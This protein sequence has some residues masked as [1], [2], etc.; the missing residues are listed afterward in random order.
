MRRIA[1]IL[2]ALALTAA[3]AAAQRDG[4]ADLR[5]TVILISLDGFRWDYPSK[6]PTPNL[7]RLMARG[8]HA[9]NLIPSFPSKTFPNHYTIVT[10]LYPGHHGI[11]AN[12]IFDP[13]TG[14][15][16]AAAKRAEVQD[17]MWWGGTPLWTL[18]DKTGR[19]SAPLFWVGS[20]APHG[21]V[22]PRYWQPYDESRPA[23]ARIDQMF[24]WLDLP[25]DQRPVFLSLYFE[26]T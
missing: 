16:F 26:D 25:A 13:P 21:G 23:Q 8:V 24:A 14:R 22:M 5:P 10:G 19:F 11:V 7:N 9:R 4:F 6:A 15:T 18:V 20:E 12:N 2:V 1:G 17:P 3:A